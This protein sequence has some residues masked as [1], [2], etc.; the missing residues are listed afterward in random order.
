MAIESVSFTPRGG[1]IVTF[2]NSKVQAR[3]GPEFME[4]IQEARARYAAEKAAK[5]TIPRK[6]LTGQDIT[7]L[8]EKYDARHISRAQYDAFLEDL[9]DRGALTEYEI[10]YLGHQGVIAQELLDG[11]GSYEVDRDG[12]PVVDINGKSLAWAKALS[13]C[14]PLTQYSIG[15]IAYTKESGS[16]L[17]AMADILKAMKCRSS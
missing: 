17:A 2:T 9:V 5:G 14:L 10:K 1:C 7:E 16:A 6:K 15:R 12:F 3:S 13:S 11:L 8:S 4:E